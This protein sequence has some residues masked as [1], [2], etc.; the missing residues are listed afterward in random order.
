MEGDVD[1]TGA[2]YPTER[3]SLA[4]LCSNFASYVLLYSVFPS[5][6][7]PL[8]FLMI[9]SICYLHKEFS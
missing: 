3:A 1:M 9:P 5:N 4:N 2:L 8:P 7:G 6:V